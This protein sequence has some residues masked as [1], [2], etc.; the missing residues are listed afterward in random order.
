MKGSK[1]K[2]EPGDMHLYQMMTFK[3]FV[4]SLEPGVDE[5]AASKRFKDFKTNLM[6]AKVDKFFDEHKHREW[7][8]LKYHPQESLPSVHKQNVSFL[9]R[10]QIFNN[11][12]NNGHFDKISYNVDHSEAILN[13]MNGVTVLLEDGPKEMAEALFNADPNIDYS[14]LE[15]YVPTKSSCIV[16]NN[17]N[18]DTN[19]SD[20]E[21]ACKTA[22]ED[23]LKICAIDPYYV[24]GGI[25]KRNFFAIYKNT[26]DIKE[27]CWKLSRS[28]VNNQD[29]DLYI[30]KI[31]ADRI[32]VVDAMSNHNLS[33]VNHIRNAIIIILNLDEL[34]GLYG[35]RKNMLETIKVKTE[36]IAAKEMKDNGVPQEAGDNDNS[37][38]GA[39]PSP[40]GSEKS[41]DSFDISSLDEDR[42]KEKKKCNDM[43]FN[44]DLSSR[45]F[46]KKLARS[47]NPLLKNAL[48]YITDYYY[49]SFLAYQLSTVREDLKSPDDIKLDQED[50]YKTIE[51]LIENLPFTPEENLQILDKMLWYLRIVHSYDFYN[52][53]LY[54]YEDEMPFKL[55]YIHVRD[56]PSK[57]NSDI[58]MISVKSYN[59]K[60]DQQFRDKTKE[61]N[62]TYLTKE[63]ERYAYRSYKKSILN[64]LES[65]AERIVNPSNVKETVDTYKCKHCTRLFQKLK[66]VGLHFVSKHRCAVDTIEIETD[67]FNSYLF[68]INKIDPLPPKHLLE[69]PL[70][71]FVV[72][73]N[74][75]NKQD[76]EESN[77]LRE[78]VESCKK[79]DPSLLREA[80]RKQEDAPDPRSEMLVDYDDIS[81]DDAI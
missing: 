24:P 37:V 40:P 20:I 22:H 9:K 73:L 78:A 17:M 43:K 11:L 47:N 7:F 4:R 41:D 42:E 28:K 75:L 31:L 71:K 34:R 1:M 8:R 63:E 21:L 46:A 13:L 53:K 45:N 5:V 25:L 2:N 77:L 39:P 15:D 70:N 35:R 6:Q 29:L 79:L 48:T 59:T 65:Y 81:F 32:R 61:Q 64:E 57:L 67:F 3:E 80:P 19:I 12:L 54:R 38:T 26:V 62:Q 69:I 49:N 52:S 76:E 18:I 74:F 51:N 36:A 55:S 60:F 56:S 10:Y 16:I 30:N 23:L 27:V 68:D 58:D 66:N 14:T 33:V 50:P 72:Q 44:L